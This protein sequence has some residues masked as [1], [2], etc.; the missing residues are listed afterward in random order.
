MAPRLDDAARQRA[1]NVLF[2]KLD[3]DR[4]SI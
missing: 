2:A 4:Q 3:T 1:G